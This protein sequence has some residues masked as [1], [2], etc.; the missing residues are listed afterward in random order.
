LADR[1]LKQGRADVEN[2]QSLPASTSSRKAKTSLTGP[3]PVSL[4]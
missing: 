1:F 3:S 4:K 2:A